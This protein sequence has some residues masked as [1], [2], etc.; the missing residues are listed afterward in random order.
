MASAVRW[1]TV[2]NWSGGVMA[3]HCANYLAQLFARYLALSV[4]TSYPT[5]HKA[6]WRRFDPLFCCLLQPV[7]LENSSASQL[8]TRFRGRT[9]CRW[10]GRPPVPNISS[11]TLCQIIGKVTISLSPVPSQDCNITSSRVGLRCRECD[12]R[13]R[14]LRRPTR[15][16]N[17]AYP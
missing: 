12:S 13:L 4:P 11:K 14:R 7:D 5:D 9:F 1:T 6:F 3:C 2:G 10:L 8:K 16:L 15:W 17:E